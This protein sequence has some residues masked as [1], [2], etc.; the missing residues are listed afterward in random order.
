MDNIHKHGE[1]IDKLL[2]RNPL[3]KYGSCLSNKMS[4]IPHQRTTRQKPAKKIQ[5]ENV[6]QDTN[7][8]ESDDPSNENGFYSS[9]GA[10]G[11]SFHMDL[12]FFRG[13]EYIVKTKM[14]QQ[15]RV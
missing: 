2:R 9:D 3:Y 15:P 10:S 8:L 1:G 11:Q 7:I 14:G 12:G 6:P 4:K 5:T 13:S